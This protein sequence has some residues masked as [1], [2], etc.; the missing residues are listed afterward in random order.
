M[1]QKTTQFSRMT[2]QAGMTLIEIIVVLA[3]GALIIGGA[4][5]LYSNASSSQA[6][7]QLNSDLTAIRASVKSLY[8]TQGGF[9]T[10]SLNSV[11][12]NA[13][14]VPTTMSVSGPTI[15]HTLNGTLT[16]TGA[17]NNFTMAVTNIETDVCVALLSAASGFT[18]IQVGANAAR[19]T[20]PI[21]PATAST[22]CAALPAQTITFTAN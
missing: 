2:R 17:T 20:F 18:S 6:S 10:A 9:S 4:L 14:K 3:I 16:V 22:D 8:S 13:K 19:T 12:I 5:S 21:P 11:L 15:N 1:N 7:N